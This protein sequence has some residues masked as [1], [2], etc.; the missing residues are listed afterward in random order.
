MITP[1]CPAH[2][3][4]NRGR[5]CVVSKSGHPKD[6]ACSQCSS[7]RLFQGPDLVLETVEFD[8][9]LADDALACQKLLNLETVIT[10]KLNNF[11]HVYGS[12]LQ[13]T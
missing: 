6:N 3:T 12:A 10:L 8:L 1:M 11:T 9:V 5:Y 2:R 4:L 13:H 7:L